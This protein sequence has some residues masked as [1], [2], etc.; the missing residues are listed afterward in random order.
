MGL[1]RSCITE[2]IMYVYMHEEVFIYIIIY[3]STHQ[4]VCG[5]SVLLLY[6]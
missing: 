2:R 4:E 5:C 3:I 1:M 6:S